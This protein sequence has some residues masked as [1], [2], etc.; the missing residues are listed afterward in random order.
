[1]SV[2]RRTRVGLVVLS[3]TALVLVALIIAGLLAQRAAVVAEPQAAPPLTF[4]PPATTA[5]AS[6]PAAAGVLS[7]RFGF[8]WVD[9]RSRQL[10]VR[11]ETGQG[12][13][14]LAAGPYRFS[15][16]SCAVSPDGT[17][18]AYWTAIPPGVELRVVE[19][20]RP[21]QQAAIYRAP[22]DRR[23]SAATWS[24]D[25]SGILFSLEGVPAPGAPVGNPPNTSLLVI[26]AGGGSARTLIGS[27]RG[28]PV[29]VP[30]G[31]DRAAGLASAGESGEGGYMRGY[32]TVRTFGDPAP[33]RTNIAED[34]LMLSVAVSTDQRFAFGLFSDPA[35][36]TL[37]WWSLGDYGTIQSGPQLDHAVGPRW[38]PLTSEIGWI[39]GGVLQ[40][41]DVEH[42]TRRAGAAFPS[43]GYGLSGFRHDGS[44]VVGSGPAM[45][46]LEIGSGRSETIGSLGYIAASVK[47]T[48][49]PVT[50][51]SSSAGAQPPLNP[52]ELK[53]ID[54]LGTLGI[55]GQ[56][57]Q[58]P[59]RNASIWADF[60][61]A[62]S[63]LFVSAYPLG[64]V[65]RNFSV[66]D[67]RQFAGIAV[68]HVRRPPDATMSSRFECSGDEYW[69]NGVV[70][71]GFADMDAFVD[72]LIRALACSR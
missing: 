36:N 14:E 23:I 53:V 68:Q 31:W 46:L 43:T 1:V 42:G 5:P 16:C 7:D 40:L 28:S 44:A 22:D 67:E 72:R 66:V 13:F 11:P 60:G 57:A 56:R 8:V 3:A 69:V 59:F 18:I 41:L 61:T 50:Q 21:T 64:T 70:P 63:A 35:R 49:P 2:G 29:Y 39:E 32:V 71:P 54:A 62:A 10:R 19:V 25:G 48:A 17:R 51:P 37:R 20:A 34:V 6:T 30:L 47:F 24:S 65:D 52:L 33:K 12:G 27:T 15:Y 4:A 9:E 26:E 55:T 45:L 38:R 58:L